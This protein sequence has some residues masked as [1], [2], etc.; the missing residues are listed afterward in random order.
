MNKKKINPR[1]RPANQADVQRAQNAARTEALRRAI[2][3][4]LFVLIDKHSASYE[5]IQQL[6]S[7]INYYADSIIK[8]YVTWKDIEHTVVKDF[9]VQLPW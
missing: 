8:G 3:L 6:A 5:D 7:E 4:I 1:R 2:Y 9:D